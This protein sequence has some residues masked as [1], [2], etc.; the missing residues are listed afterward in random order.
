MEK[1]TVKRRREIEGKLRQ[2]RKLERKIK[3][4]N[5]D[6]WKMVERVGRRIDKKD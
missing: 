4:E 1:K 3:A 5:G 6:R 2:Y